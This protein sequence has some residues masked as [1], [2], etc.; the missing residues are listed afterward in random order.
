MNRQ[1]QSSI[2]EML[3]SFGQTTQN[4]EVFLVTLER[5]CAGLSDQ[6][7]TEAA[8]RFAAGD[9]KDQSKKFP[10]SGPE[11]IEEV[12]RRQEY[13]E[14][15]ARPRIAPPKYVPG[16]LAP[17]EIARQK[18]FSSYGHLPMLLENISYDEWRRLSTTKQVPTGAIWVAALGIVY[19]PQP[20]RKAA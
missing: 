12:R 9:V 16:P 3:N 13:L 10:P 6:A 5:L 8:D 1:A 7:I 2:T 11:F 15:K 4:Y 17:F 18:A 19:G 14:L 20:A